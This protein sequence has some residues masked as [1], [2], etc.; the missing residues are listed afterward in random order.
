[1]QELIYNWGLFPKNRCNIHSVHNYD[2]IINL[3]K[4]NNNIIARGFGRCYG[5]ASLANNIFSTL[6]LNKILNFDEYRGIICCQSGV[7][8]DDILTKII[9]K[10]FFL[11]VTPGTKFIT[12]GGA[13][14]SDIHGKNHHVDGVFS[15][16]VNSFKLIN[17]DAQIINVL[18]NDDLFIQTAGG[19]GGTGIIIEITFKLK[20][21]ETSFILQKSIRANNLKEIFH[22][23]ESHK[24][25]TYSVAWIDCLAKGKDIGKSVL[26]LGEH[27]L[28][29][30]L[31]SKNNLIVHKKPLLN[32][33]INFPNWVLNP[34]SIRIFNFLFFNKPSSNCESVMHYDSYFY[35]LDKIN[36][37][38]KIYGKKGFIQYQFVLPITHSYEGVSDILKILSKHK[39]GS[40]LAVLKLFG[41]SHENRYLH[42]PMEGYT[43]ALDIKVSP[44]IW[45]VLDQLDE[46]VNKFNGKV[47]LTKD[48]R[49]KKLS[50]EKQY[51][52]R[53]SNTTKF[54]SHQMTRLSNSNN[55]TFLILGANS[56]IAKATALKYL[57]KYPNGHLLLASR[58]TNELNEFVK[59]NN[60]QNNATVIF[61]DSSPSN[62]NKQFVANLPNKPTWIMYAAGILVENDVAINDQTI[63]ENNVYVNYTGGVSVLNELINDNNPFLNRVIGIS[64]IA[65]LRGRKLNYIYGSSKSGFHQYLFGL[66][67]ALKTTNILVQAVTPGFVKTKMTKEIPLNKFANTADQVAESIISD[68][69]SFEIYP[70]LKW[71]IISLFVKFA[72]EFLINKI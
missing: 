9:P 25:A 7:L 6:S 20:K 66:R 40:F 42:F 13:L 4:T 12:V 15:D 53:S 45:N 27:A 34:L 54:F 71:K 18:P 38:N 49:M 63:W 37:W 57:I 68:S 32:I 16:H 60:I 28:M 48:A 36:N 72:P 44:N 67:Q 61:Y 41:K 59:L 5:D 29:K 65:G 47:Y 35:P 3:I 1:M 56:D 14:A 31:K 46:I 30:D 17:T 26:L 24:N 64:S 2:E 23:F 69:T 8:L 70:N 33:P 62:N 55:H 10:G 58:N 39:L 19:M 22:L 52:N 11:P 43:L 21:I 51:C 50:Y